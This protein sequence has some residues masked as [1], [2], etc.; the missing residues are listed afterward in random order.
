MLYRFP[1]DKERLKRWEIAVNRDHDWTPTSSSVVCSEHFD[2]SNFYLTESGL[3]RL[4]REAVPSIN[5][6]VSKETRSTHKS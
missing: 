3:R 2:A 1:L 5:I 6:S 4:S